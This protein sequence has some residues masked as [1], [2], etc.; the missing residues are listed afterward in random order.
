MKRMW[1]LVVPLLLLYGPPVF[2]GSIGLMAAG[3]EDPMVN[4]FCTGSGAPASCCTGSGTGTCGDMNA[5]CRSAGVPLTCCTGLNTGTC[6]TITLAPRTVYAGD[7]HRFIAADFDDSTSPRC[8][9]WHFPLPPDYPTNQ[10]MTI[11]LNLYNRGTS[12]SGIQLWHVD[13][14]CVNNGVD[15][16]QG[17]EFLGSTEWNTTSPPATVGLLWQA[18]TPGAAGATAVGATCTAGDAA[19]VRLCRS[20]GDSN[21]NNM[22]VV[23]LTLQY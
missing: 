21:T 19:T 4:S 6:G 8:I 11:W 7:Q 12:A 2:A 9:I 5:T 10:N 14:M 18:G 1:W 23:D 13:M 15:Y 3:A 20:G 16:R 22:S 17:D